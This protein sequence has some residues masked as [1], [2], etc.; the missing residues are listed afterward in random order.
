MTLSESAMRAAIRTLGA[1]PEPIQRVIAGKPTVID[2]N[3]LFTEV[4]MALRVL[5]ALPG[6]AF[7]DL[8]LPEAR[9]Q[10]DAEARI[11]GSKIDVDAVHD[12]VV[13][14]RNGSVPARVYRHRT[15]D[16]ILGAVTYFHGGGWVVGSLDSTDAV[17]RFIAHHLRVVVISVDY[18]LA[19]EHPYPAA[20]E[21]AID[22][23]RWVREQPEWGEVVA[24]AGDSAGGNLAAVVANLTRDDNPPD[25]QLLF[26]PV[27][28]LSTE[29]PSYAKFAEGYFLTR[30][31]MHW[32]RDHYVPNPDQRTDAAVSPLFEDLGDGSGIAPAHVAVAGFDVLRDEGIAYAKALQTVGVPTTLQVV[33]GHIHAFTNATGVGKTGKAALGEA[34][35]S[36]GHL[37]QQARRKNG[38]AETMKP[39]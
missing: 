12:I 10:I 36:L 1:L 22:A 20:V 6:N 33:P 28:D 24:V 2:G 19:P 32:Y 31:Q 34:V 5:N 37:L 21:D 30:K 4:Q 8:P 39:R 14:T 35:K 23:Y 9:E 16:A 38:E 15:S 29:H 3:Q 18:R 26:F 7:E 11:F 27:T 13:P 17:C 25:A